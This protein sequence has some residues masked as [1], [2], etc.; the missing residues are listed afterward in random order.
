MPKKEPL[1]GTYCLLIH[2]KQDSKITIGKLGEKNFTKRILYIRGL[3]LKLPK[4]PHTKTSREEKKIYWHIDYL[5]N[6]ENTEII[7]VIYTINDIKWECKIA[8]TIAETGIGVI[9]FGCSDCKCNSHLLYFTKIQDSR[10]ASINTL[11]KFNL[12]VNKYSE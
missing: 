7:E 1:K 2:L 4:N 3:R 5:L 9:N 12:N 8:A 6:N 10:N 11:K